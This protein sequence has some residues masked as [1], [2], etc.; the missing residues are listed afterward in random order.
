MQ[1]TI[2]APTTTSPHS[3]LKA[4]S[5]I[6]DECKDSH[7]LQTLF[8]AMATHGDDP[9]IQEFSCRCLAKLIGC[10]EFACEYIGDNDDQI[11]VHSSVMAAA[12]VHTGDALVFRAACA[13]IYCIASGSEE[14]QEVVILY[15]ASARLKG[16]VL[17]GVL[18][19]W[20]IP[21]TDDTNYILLY[22]HTFTW[23]GFV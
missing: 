8:T 7:W 4:N 13:A 21:N 18:G 3:I 6:A 19:V 22:F 20:T 1:A 11:P 14:L 12:M 9:L 15:T 16:C 2:T 10:C 17:K 23:H 5:T